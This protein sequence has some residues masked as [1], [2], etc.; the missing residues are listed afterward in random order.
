MLYT[1]YIIYYNLAFYL[2]IVKDLI[3]ALYIILKQ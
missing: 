1:V 3:Q 2:K